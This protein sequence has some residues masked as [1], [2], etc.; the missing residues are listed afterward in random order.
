VHRIAIKDRN[1]WLQLATITISTN[2]GTADQLRE[3]CLAT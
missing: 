3:L 1:D 2:K